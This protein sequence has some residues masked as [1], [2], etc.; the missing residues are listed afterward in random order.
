MGWRSKLLARPPWAFYPRPV[1]LLCISDIHGHADALAAVL[2]TAERRGYQK[3][4]VAGDLCFPGVKPLETW[5]R[6]MQAGAVCAQGV[7]DRALATIDP[8]TLHP[9]SEHERDRQG[10]LA[11]VRHELGEL[12][13]ARLAR[14]PP[15]V[16]L[17]L[18]DGGELVLVHG[19][20]AD[21]TEPISH[22]MSDAEISALLGDD[23]ADVVICGGSHVPFDRLV[24]SG[25]GCVR[26]INVGSVGEAPRGHAPF[27][28][29]DATLV[30]IY[31]LEKSRTSSAEG[32]KVEQISVPLGKAA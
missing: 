4:L 32:V 20:P 19:S 8:A 16:R 29:A 28:H 17:P 25:G 24:T 23:P 10:R 1:R 30:E 2:A 11:A 6:L 5:R 3:L 9:R 12:I 21:P 18:D 31:G 26:V 27:P 13:L 15:T 7:G 14:L 22:D